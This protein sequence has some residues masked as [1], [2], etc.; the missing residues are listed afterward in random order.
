M[1]TRQFVIRLLELNPYPE[2]IDLHMHI[3]GCL[4]S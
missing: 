2:D 1:T 4:I 3:F